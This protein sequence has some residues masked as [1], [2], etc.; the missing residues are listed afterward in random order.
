M[1]RFRRI[2][3]MGSAGQLGTALRS[4]L[5]A[6]G[7]ELVCL[8][9]P[10]VDFADPH[11][12]AAA[13]A[14][15]RPDLV[16]NAA[17][18]TSVDRAENEPELAHAI[19]ARAPGIIAEAS[20]ACAAPIIHVSTDYVF[21]G[22]SQAPYDEK[23]T[24]APVTV[25][26]RT[27]LEGERRVAAA[28]PRHVILRTAW[29]CSPHGRNFVKT[30]LALAA[31]QPLLRVV[32]DQIGCPTFADDLAE[33]VSAL[34][35]RLPQLAESE[36]WGVF[37]AVNGGTA[38]WCAFAR[39]IMAGSR[40]RGGPHVPVEAITSAQYPTNARRPANSVLS[41][42]KL[43]SAYGLAMRP[44]QHALDD[45]LDKLLVTGTE[46]TTQTRTER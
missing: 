19:N 7:Y 28:N 10:D 30:M 38:T 14:A 15:A 23:D 18:Y 43:Q 42:A 17:A 3:V 41:T 12:L 33:L 24:A 6:A 26:G 16:V 11:A 36:R 46:T 39:A 4:R 9:R 22:E 29:L 1:K 31:R 40:V 27:K 13:I 37:H 21:D 20:A 35:P 32:D 34:I 2:V 8:A 25:Y 45:C 5:N 44:W